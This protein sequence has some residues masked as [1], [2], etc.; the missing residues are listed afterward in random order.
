MLRN[1]QPGLDAL[2][3]QGYSMDDLDMQSVLSFKQKV[4]LRYPKKHYMEMDNQKFL[5]EIGLCR[6]ERGI[7]TGTGKF[8]VLRGALLCLGKINAIKEQYPHFHVDFFNYRGNNARWTD[9]V[10]DDEPSDY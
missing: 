6:R 5:T 8:E 9:R 1:A 3:V 10:S 2:P 4:S 7:E